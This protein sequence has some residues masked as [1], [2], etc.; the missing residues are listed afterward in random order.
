MSATHDSGGRT[1]TL[2]L[3]A[4]AGFAVMVAAFI[5]SPLRVLTYF[6]GVPEPEI[7]APPPLKMATLPPK[8]SFAEI[9]ARPIFNQNRKP[10]PARDVPMSGESVAEEASDISQF[11]VV[12]IVT[13][14]ELQLALVQTP[15]GT[16]AR[17]RAGD[18]IEGWRI[19]KVD[20][21]GVTAS[22]GTR[23]ARLVIP[24]APNTAATP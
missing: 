8:D 15:G 17:V 2:A 16:T 11:K 21:S 13:D 10:D 22:D 19:E 18:T 24:R 7:E 3:I 1:R 5:P 20:V 9:T 14:R 23:S 12:G 4:L 6:E